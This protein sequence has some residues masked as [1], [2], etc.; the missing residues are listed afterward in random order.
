MSNHDQ[1]ISVPFSPVK[2]DDLICGSP[3]D[4]ENR[5]KERKNTLRWDKTRR[6]RFAS[7]QARLLMEV[8]DY[9]LFHMLRQFCV[10][11]GD[12]K[13]SMEWLIKRLI[14]VGA[15]VA[16]RS[17]RWRVNVDSAFPLSRYYRA[18]FG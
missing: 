14:N 7:N 10:V 17:R 16:Y 18:L 4:V 9:S 13:R 1:V 5:L 2:P 12:V 11:G 6:H 8:L 15:K 3:G